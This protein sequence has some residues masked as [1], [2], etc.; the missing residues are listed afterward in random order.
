MR[1][2]PDLQAFG[3][4]KLHRSASVLIAAEYVPD[5][6]LVQAGQPRRNGIRGTRAFFFAGDT[7]RRGI[8]CEAGGPWG[9]NP[10]TTLTGKKTAPLRCSTYPSWCRHWRICADTVR[11]ITAR[12]GL[13]YSM[14]EI[15]FLAWFLRNARYLMNT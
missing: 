4:V 2:P 13:T 3:A 5:I 11:V 12:R 6:W 14:M 9:K 1:E 10:V 8:Q 7:A 15:K